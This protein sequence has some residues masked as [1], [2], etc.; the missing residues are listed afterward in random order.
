[1]EHLGLPTSHVTSTTTVRCTKRIQTI[2]VH[3]KDGPVERTE[4]V[5]EGGPECQ[6]AADHTK[7]GLGAFFPTLTH[8]SSSSSSSYSGDAKGS[9]L[10]G[11]KTGFGD[12]F[13]GGAGFDLGAFMTDNAEDD[14]PDFHARSVKSTR[15]ERQ[16]DFVGTGTGTSDLE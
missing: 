8:T 13:A 4:E 6:A 15:I 14:Q 11:T 5:M 7:G 9:L 2:V 16:A 12:P 1:M 3:T 10:G